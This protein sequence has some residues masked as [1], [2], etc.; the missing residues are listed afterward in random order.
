MGFTEE[1]PNDRQ[2]TLHVDRIICEDDM[3]LIHQHIEEPGMPTT[4]F[5]DLFRVENE[6]IAEHWDVI[7]PVPEHPKNTRVSMY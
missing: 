6:R 1:A 3:V 5:M 4:V 2:L 7:Q